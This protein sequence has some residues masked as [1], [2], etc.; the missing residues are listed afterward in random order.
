MVP[1][2]PFAFRNLAFLRLAGVAA[3][4]VSAIA[5]AQVWMRD[6]SEVTAALALAA[7]AYLGSH[8]VRALRLVLLSAHPEVPVRSMF[9]AHFYAAAVS[10]ATPFKVGDVL[11]FAEIARLTRSAPQAL[12]IYWAER[13]SDAFVL[14]ALCLLMLFVLGAAFAAAIPF[15]ASL[16]LFVMLTAAV[17][18]V[19]PEHIRRIKIFAL[20]KYS[21]E[22]AGQV[23]EV[24]NG[25]RA[26]GE[27]C[28]SV[29]RGKLSTVI[30][31]SMAVW[32]L[33]I[34]A[35]ARATQAFG[36]ADAVAGLTTQLSTMSF[37]WPPLDA[38]FIAS[39]AERMRGHSGVIFAV[40]MPLGLASAPMYF[41][42]LA[43][44]N[45]RDDRLF[46]T[47]GVKA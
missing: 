22:R 31:L 10:A 16:V 45:R 32:V 21:G 41:Q 37:T 8:V 40:L 42:S 36:A 33:E 3:L 27:A 15:M 34:A 17:L 7:G 35:Y 20:R 5:L 28:R 44:L 12:A 46:P 14:V 1:R 2:V 23:I 11:R 24:L 19:L 18:I 6:Q 47:R 30:L 43:R 26:F 9:F 25:L 38:D 29:A 4:L 13:A 39:L